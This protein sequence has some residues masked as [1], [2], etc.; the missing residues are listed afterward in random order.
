MGEE[1]PPIIL[2]G[3][4][5]A[6]DDLTGRDL[7]LALANNL[8]PNFDPD[9]GAAVL[10]KL[11]M[12]FDY[13]T[14]LILAGLNEPDRRKNLESIGREISGGNP[15][16]ASRL[17]DA[18]SKARQVFMERAVAA[19]REAA[20]KPEGSRVETL[21]NVFRRDCISAQLNVFQ[22]A[23]VSM[24][25]EKP[26]HLSPS[27]NPIFWGAADS[28]RPIE[29]YMRRNI[30][31]FILDEIKTRGN[32]LSRM[33][34][35]SQAPEG[36]PQR[37]RVGNSFVVLADG[38]D[39]YAVNLIIYGTL[40]SDLM[41]SWTAGRTNENNSVVFE[42]GGKEAIERFLAAVDV[43]AKGHESGT[44][45]NY[46]IIIEAMSG[47]FPEETMEIVK[48]HMFRWQ[49]IQRVIDLRKGNPGG[50]D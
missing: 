32:E 46:R 7:A 49:E 20:A 50:G 25:R 43:D 21:S 18:F 5:E 31:Y 44:K 27:K 47:V 30:K 38:N 3:S 4:Q 19:S 10:E 40:C 12:A 2:K 23:D 11:K 34:I 39:G 9:A 24:I 48:S 13:R 6:K 1:K 22:L 14:L 36:D 33:Q 26:G 35:Y 8:F 29:G 37:H 16:V 42:L 17:P 15:T 41:G 28:C 45:N